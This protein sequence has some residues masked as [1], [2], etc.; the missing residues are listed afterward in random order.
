MRTR[1]WIVGGACTVL[2][3]VAGY[4]YWSVTTAQ[5]ET[6]HAAPLSSIVAVAPAVDAAWFAS[7][8]GGTPGPDASCR[9]CHAE[10]VSGTAG[11]SGGMH[12]TLV[13]TACHGDKPILASSATASES[14]THPVER[15]ENFVGAALCVGCHA[16]SG[17]V[18]AYGK[19]HVETFEEWRRTPAAAEGRSCLACHGEGGHDPGGRNDKAL[20][21]S[22]FVASAKFISNGDRLVGK[23]TV[24]ATAV[25]HRLPT[26]P[27]HE[28]LMQ[29][30]QVDR[31][32]LGLDDTRSEGILGRRLT[33]AGRELFDTR[34]MPGESKILHYESRLDRDAAAIVARLLKYT[35]GSEGPIVF[36]EQRVE[37]PGAD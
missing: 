35:G 4:A 30:E 7:R 21:A 32:K 3:G 36:W 15:S 34:L 27:N 20:I 9:E 31:G 24:R 23:L 25:G 1:L 6:A 19:R 29:I 28:L 12:A 11:L 33:D 17:E 8:L 2:L 14:A 13:C 37:L 16:D 10:A 26:V 18:D 5:L 22:G